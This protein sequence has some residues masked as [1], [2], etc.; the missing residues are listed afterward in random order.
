M[1]SPSWLASLSA[2]AL[3]TEASRG[4]AVAQAAP[5]LARI[6]YRP[7]ADSVRPDGLMRSR[8]HMCWLFGGSCTRLRRAQLVVSLASDARRLVV[9]GDRHAGDEHDRNGRIQ[10][11]H[12]VSARIMNAGMPGQF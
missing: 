12:L 4:R 10:L 3:M 8:D 9:D 1:V 6:C 2:K 11:G 7:S 5:N